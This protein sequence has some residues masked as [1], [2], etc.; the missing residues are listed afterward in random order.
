MQFLGES[1]TVGTK[2]RAMVKT[3]DQLMG[4][5]WT[6]TS[7]GGLEKS[8]AFFKFNSKKREK[9]GKMIE[10]TI[11]LNPK[12]KLCIIDNNGWGYDESMVSSFIIQRDETYNTFT[13]DMGDFDVVGRNDGCVSLVFGGDHD[14]E[15]EL[16]KQET[17][18]LTKQLIRYYGWID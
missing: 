9:I 7:K 16:S 8:S 12:R 15:Y 3:A 1:V 11:T 14:I 5:G 17:K 18:E 4:E 13:I 2:V 10:G 6:P